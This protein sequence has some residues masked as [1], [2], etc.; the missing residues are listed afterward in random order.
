MQSFLKHQCLF[1]VYFPLMENIG[2]I[3]STLGADLNG[4]C[5]GAAW[6]LHFILV[7]SVQMGTIGSLSLTFFQSIFIMPPQ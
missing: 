1:H 5:L 6:D 2:G 3:F 4:L 7:V